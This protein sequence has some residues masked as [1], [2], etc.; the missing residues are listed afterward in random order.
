[1]CLNVNGSL[2]N[3]LECI[4]FVNS[5]VCHDIIVL[6]E[7]WINANSVLN[8]NGFEC[9]SKYRRRRKRA[10]RDSGGICCFVSK[11]I[12][13][14]IEHIEWDF[15]D[16]IIILL[17]KSF[18]HFDEDLYFVCPYIKPAS[19]SRNEIETGPDI[20]D[21]LCSKLA[22][23]RQNGE[24]MLMGDFKSRLG[25]TV[26]YNFRDVDDNFLFDNDPEFDH[27]ISVDDVERFGIS[28]E[29][30]CMDNVTNA[31]GR[32]LAEL[33]VMSNML[34]LNGRAHK[35]AGVGKYT[36][37]TFNGQSV[38]DYVLCSKDVLRLLIDFAVSDFKA[39][40]D[41]AIMSFKL[42]CNVIHDEHI[43]QRNVQLKP[44]WKDEMKD[45]YV[46]NLMRPDNVNKLSDLLCQLSEMCNDSTIN[47]CVS[48]LSDV[49]TSAGECKHSNVGQTE[50]KGR[51]N[52]GKWYD[53]MCIEKRVLFNEAERTFAR[54]GDPVDRHSMC[55]ARNVYRKCCRLKRKEYKLSQAKA[56]LSL[57]RH[58]PKQFWKKIKPKKKKVIGKCNFH[59]YF[60]NLNNIH[61]FMGDDEEE[62]VNDWERGGITIR[63]IILDAD[64]CE[65]ELDTAINKLKHDKSPGIDLIIN[66]YIM[67]STPLVKSVILKLFNTIFN[68]GL[69]P[70]IWA[71]GEIIPIH[72]KGDINDPS[73]YRGITLLS[74]LGKLFTNV[75]NNRLTAWA[76]ENDIY[77]EN[78]FGFRKSRGITDCMF[79]LHGIIQLLLNHSKTLFCAFV[80][81]ERAFD[82]TNRRALWYKLNNCKMSTKVNDL[83]QNMY[84]KIK[85]CVKGTQSKCNDMHC[86][87]ENCNNV[88]NDANECNDMFGNVDNNPHSCYF[89]SVAGVFQGESLSPFLFSMFLN[90]LSENLKCND[91]VGIKFNEWLLTVLLF[92]DDMVIF[93]ETRNGLQTGLNKLD[94][95]CSRWG[96]TVNINKTKCVAFRNGGKIGQLDRWT[97]RN[98]Q[99][100]T[101][102]QFEYLGFV[103]GASGK[104]TKG[105]EDLKVR[106]LRALFA[107]KSIIYKHSDLAPSIQL[108]LFDSLVRP[109]LTS[110]CEIWGFDD[111]T[112]LDT[113][114]LGFLKSVLGV[115]TNVPTPYIYCELG[116][117]P[118]KIE[119]YKRIIKYWVKILKLDTNNPM[120]KMYTLLVNDID[121]HNTL[122][123]GN[124]TN[125][126]AAVKY[127]LDTHGL[128]YIWEQQSGPAVDRFLHIF[129]TKN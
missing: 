109:I 50:C 71:T 78:Q 36:C 59:E 108:K 56:L 81:L 82:G 76:E 21:I 120:K 22:E 89:S 55:V 34:V 39:F 125:W 31:Y 18:F 126:A 15:E 17:K 47:D 37:C 45:V 62:M 26:D 123:R 25:K 102:N 64:I 118:L 91:E 86:N 100:E 90:D 121:H 94:E 79:I 67:H 10:K 1:M 23:L 88:Q 122:P 54:T 80:D 83:I 106:S 49:M 111:A 105:L 52:Q 74:C 101:V 57:N 127:I 93:S 65:E 97:Y 28:V 73:N 41:H 60:K 104:F 58:D 4:E 110:S 124:V 42:K 107:L 43:M 129:F 51:V 38:V 63:D 30:A 32:K 8:L 53:S 128:G 7:C 95:Y 13:P 116:V 103:F 68:T 77:C 5:L 35:D 119:R 27:L 85:L 70:E 112:H 20:F 46:N 9:I 84:S 33:C 115:R 61:P 114:Y 44:H 75:I 66:E 12:W 72:K 11:R 2:E 16:G 14:G 48:K 40:S 29:R 87:T 96:L 24:I 98:V 3:K 19:S 69:F 99:L 92:A 117:T 6:S 113:V